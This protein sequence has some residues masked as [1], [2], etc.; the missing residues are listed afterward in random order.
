MCRECHIEI[1]DDDDPAD[2]DPTDDN[3]VCDPQ[4]ELNNHY[5]IF[6]NKLVNKYPKFMH[7]LYSGYHF[8]N[9][10][11]GLILPAQCN[12]DYINININKSVF[13]DNKGKDK[14][15]EKDIDDDD[16]D[17]NKTLNELKND[18]KEYLK[19]YIRT[20]LKQ[21]IINELKPEI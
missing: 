9:E 16:I 8:N 1:G 20:N 12:I 13:N 14:D 4:D 17:L 11:S 5:L 18:I 6:H 21:E 19:K 2:D 7:R 15:K 3:H 10:R